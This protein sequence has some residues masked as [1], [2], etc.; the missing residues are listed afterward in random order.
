[1]EKRNRGRKSG[2]VPKF[3]NSEE[4]GGNTKPPLDTCSH[5]ALRDARRQRLHICACN[6]RACGCN[7]ILQGS[8]AVELENL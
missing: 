7:Y 8:G 2:S 4:E 5:P 3:R 6:R 1:M